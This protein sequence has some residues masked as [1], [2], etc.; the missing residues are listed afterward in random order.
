MLH[1]FLAFAIALM[2][3]Y[4]IAIFNHKRVLARQGSR[5]SHESAPAFIIKR[6]SAM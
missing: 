4:F 5:R 3:N 6:Q 1:V 2:A